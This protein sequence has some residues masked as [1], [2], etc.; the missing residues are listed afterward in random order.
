MALTAGLF[1]DDLVTDVLYED[2]RRDSVVFRTFSESAEAQE[3]LRRALTEG[4]AGGF[5][6]KL[7][8]PRL[9]Q[10]TLDPTDGY[11]AASYPGSE[12]V[13]LSSAYSVLTDDYAE[14]SINKH[15]IGTFRLPKVHAM[16]HAA[17]ALLSNA[18]LRADMQEIKDNVEEGF[19][20]DMITQARYASVA[21][22][23]PTKFALDTT[24]QSALMSDLALLEGD[25]AAQNVPEAEEKFM[26][27]NPAAKGH[28]LQYPSVISR[29]VMSQPGDIREGALDKIMGFNVIYSNSISSDSGFIIARSRAAIVMP[30]GFIVEILDDIDTVSYYGRVWCVC[31]W[32]PL[33]K[34]VN[35][36]DGD[37]WSLSHEGIVALDVTLS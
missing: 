30:T 22:G 21:A 8:I 27:L 37:A 31:G 29:D 26:V 19:C 20:K 35:A 3:L 33:G 13:D 16:T 25:F 17:G 32:A 23:V 14:L 24:S 18:K 4:P 34:T 5:A 6:K 9:N 11:T 15:F 36:A 28:L 10:S 1:K 2:F 7:T 12:D